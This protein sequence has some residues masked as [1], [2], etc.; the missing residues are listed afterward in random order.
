MVQE[1]P[2]VAIITKIRANA[3]LSALI[4]VSR[5]HEGFPNDDPDLPGIYVRSGRSPMKQ[6]C[7]SANQINPVL[8]GTGRWYVDTFSGESIS[9]A[10]FL[11]RVAS[12]AV[13]PQIPTAGLYSINITLVDSY[14]DKTFNCY[15][16]LYQIDVP[17]REWTCGV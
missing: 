7:S 1:D 3:R 9:N 6:I 11:G 12:E 2:L 4:A 16:S 13:L 5:V 15:R 14:R 17:F 10:E 8:N